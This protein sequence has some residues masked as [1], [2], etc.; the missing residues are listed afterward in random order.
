MR[1]E[2]KTEGN[3]G[4]RKLEVS[5]VRSGLESSEAYLIRKQRIGL[6]QVRRQAMEVPCQT[7]FLLYPPPTLFS[8]CCTLLG[9]PPAAPPS[10]PAPPP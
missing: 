2:T 8:P 6:G 9:P 5:G 4:E 1:R 3:E 10:L 7:A